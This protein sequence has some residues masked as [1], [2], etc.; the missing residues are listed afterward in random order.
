MFAHQNEPLSTIIA[1]AYTDFIRDL[2]EHS[3]LL[4]PITF[5]PVLGGVNE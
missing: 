4:D 2:I 3:L 5:L 1:K